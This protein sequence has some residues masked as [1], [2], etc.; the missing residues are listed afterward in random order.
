MAQKSGSS[1]GISPDLQQQ[2]L[3]FDAGSNAVAAQPGDGL[4][5][6]RPLDANISAVKAMT[7]AP[8][9]SVYV[10]GSASGTVAG[11]TP[12]GRVG[13]GPDEVRLPRAT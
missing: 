2:L 6:Q 3:K 7:T 8:D 4:T 13:H 9:G 1:S 5:F 10:L 12:Q 11:Q